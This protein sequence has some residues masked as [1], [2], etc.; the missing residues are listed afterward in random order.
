MWFLISS[1]H[2]SLSQDKAEMGGMLH[3]V[4]VKGPELSVVLPIFRN[5][6]LWGAGIN[7]LPSTLWERDTEMPSHH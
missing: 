5:C 2:P 1:W 6:E 4:Q 7:S 3:R